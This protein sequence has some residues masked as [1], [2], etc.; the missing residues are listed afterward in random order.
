MVASLNTF[1]FPFFNN[2]NKVEKRYLIFMTLKNKILVKYTLAFVLIATLQSCKNENE[3]ET[4]ISSHGDDQSHNLGQNC[5][6]CHKQGGSGEGWFTIAGTI[7]DS[8]NSITYPN[9]TVKL[10]TGPNG[11]GTLKY[12][13]NADALG[14][15][16]TTEKID[17]GNGLYPMVKGNVISNYM[18]SA[19][20]SGQCNSC[21]GI[22]T[23]K[24]WTK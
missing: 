15:F 21:H 24:I 10:F 19:T 14:N 12:T 3:N 5:M 4:K 20:S 8:L 7:Y 6:N 23:D 22:S 16:Y 18:S 11:T 2:N 17:F 9:A 13:V 1:L